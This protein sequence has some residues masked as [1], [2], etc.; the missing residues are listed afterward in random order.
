MMG[1][2]PPLPPFAYNLMDAARERGIERV[3]ELADHS[4]VPEP[5]LREHM[6]GRHEVLDLEGMLYPVLDALGIPEEDEE[7][8]PLCRSYAFVPPPQY[9]P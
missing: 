2:Q 5:V 8:W 9:W 6:E 1:E 4:G 7:W 3:D